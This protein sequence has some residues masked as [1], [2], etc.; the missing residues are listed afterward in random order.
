[1]PL[2]DDPAIL[3]S[4]A[5]HVKAIVAQFDALRPA[6]AAFDTQ[7][8]EL[9]DAHEDAALFRSL[10]GA[11]SNL[12]ARLLTAFGTDRQKF[13]SAR[14]IQDF[15]GISPVL[16]QSGKKRMVL[17]RH[18]CPAFV[19][20]SFLEWVGQTLTKSQWARAY[21]ERQKARGVKTYTA[22]RALAYKWIRIIWRCWQDRTPYDETVY[23]EALT[24]RN[25]PLVPAIRELQNISTKL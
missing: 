8:A 3:E 15:S 24:R 20:Q 2:T 25:S 18:A 14:A 7:I 21:Y 10:P 19:R 11:G 17:R 1:M 5:L 4:S 9:L 23:I 6:I 16:R 22:R 12:A 13:P